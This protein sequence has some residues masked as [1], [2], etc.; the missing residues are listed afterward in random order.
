MVKHARDDR[1]GLWDGF[2]SGL[3][4]AVELAVVPLLFGLAG[5]WLD[6][7]LGTK[8]ALTL[9]L[10][11]FAFVG[12]FVKAYYEYV[13]RVREEEREKPWNRSTR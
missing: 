8:P 11:C 13:A 6:R 5:A 7:S 4:M 10:L 2:G 12:T 9:T 1:R 3:Q